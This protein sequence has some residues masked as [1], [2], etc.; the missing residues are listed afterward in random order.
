MKTNIVLLGGLVLLALWWATRQSRDV[1]AETVIDASPERVWR[2]M[3]DT[4][5]YPEW[6]PVIVRLTGELRAGETVEFV[7][8]GLDGQTMTFRPRI[9]KAEAGRELRWLGHLW[10]PGLFDGEHYFVLS[11][12]PGGKTRLQHGEHF[13]GVLVPAV[14][15]WLDRA[16]RPNYA[17]LNAALKERA[18]QLSGP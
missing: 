5:A 16:I 1:E 15:G 4:A 8:R 6:N 12:L 3:A 18:E 9:L 17:R 10:V 14:S 7:N 13:R 11:A 2:V